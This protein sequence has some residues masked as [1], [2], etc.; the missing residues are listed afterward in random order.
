MEGG[1][2]GMGDGEGKRQWREG[3]LKDTKAVDILK[4][5]NRRNSE[6]WEK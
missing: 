4:W 1:S 3:D 6:D 5:K 2:G